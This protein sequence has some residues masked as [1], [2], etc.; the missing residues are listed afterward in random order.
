MSMALF[1]PRRVDSGDH[2]TVQAWSA[3]ER[4]AELHQALF[5]ALG[6]SPNGQL[7]KLKL[8]KDH[9][10]DGLDCYVAPFRDHCS[11]SGIVLLVFQQDVPDTVINVSCQTAG[12]KHFR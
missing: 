3:L 4:E 9:Q 1:V 11:T 8:K 2:Q 5:S 7:R 12:S 10:I 6:S